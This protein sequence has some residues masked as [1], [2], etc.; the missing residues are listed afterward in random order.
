MKRYFLSILLFIFFFTRLAAQDSAH[1]VV[2]F[3][4]GKYELS[5]TAKNSLI[6]LAGTFYRAYPEND[7][8]NV[9]LY[10]TAYTDSVGSYENNLQLA[11]Q[12]AEAITIFLKNVG[13]PETIIKTRAA[14][15]IN[16]PCTGITDKGCPDFRYAL[17]EYKRVVSD[18]VPNDKNKLYEMLQTPCD[19]FCIDPG[20]DTV[21]AGNKGTIVVYKA[22]SL[23]LPANPCH[24]VQ[25][26]LHE[27]RSSSEMVLNNLSTVSNGAPL[28][29]AGMVKLEAWCNKELLSFKTGQYL[30]I[31]QPADTLLPGMQLFAASRNE[32]KDPLNWIAER[33]EALDVVNM[34]RMWYCMSN[35]ARLPA[36]RC[37][38]FFCRIRRFLNMW[39]SK[40]AEKNLEQYNDALNEEMAM[41]KKYNFSEGDIASMLQKAGNKAEVLKYYVYKNFSWDYRNIDR[42]MKGFNY[43]DIYV[44]GNDQRAGNIDVKLVYDKIKMAIPAV[45]QK[46]RFAFIDVISK[47]TAWLVGLEMAANNQINFSLSQVNT[48]DRNQQLNLQPATP[49]EIKDALKVLDNL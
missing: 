30:T 37:P 24:C 8:D 32:L 46:R 20:R 47:K 10:V 36:Q 33:E 1:T 49:K 6:Y 17:V 19:T 13:I 21:L 44:K 12:R 4:F 35:A 15:E 42:Y 11:T 41:I 40:K 29:S 25:L 28:E 18:F 31:M 48:S 7:R 23:Q 38:L 34:R 14:G 22:N 2:Y 9:F 3:E 5:E 16:F 39:N 26:L 43:T 27:Y 45:L